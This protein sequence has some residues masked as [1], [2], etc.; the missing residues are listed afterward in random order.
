MSRAVGLVSGMVAAILVV[1]CGAGKPSK[2]ELR[3][4]LAAQV[5]RA[6]EVDSFDVEDT[7]DLGVS[8]SPLM[9]TQF[10]AK[11]HARENTYAM[12]RME[13]D[14]ALIKPVLP[15][16]EQRTLFGTATSTR[17]G[18]AWQTTLVFAS[19]A[20]APDGKARAELG[21]R[22]VLI[23]TDEERKYRLEL[24]EARRRQV[25]AR[26]AAFSR[27]IASLVESG[28]VLECEQ[29]T[30]DKKTFPCRFAVASFDANTGDVVAT[31][32]WFSLKTGALKPPNRVRGTLKDGILNLTEQIKRSE[33]GKNFTMHY[34]LQ[35][36][37]AQDALAGEF[38]APGG[39]GAMR[40]KLQ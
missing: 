40:V 13:G 21:R 27:L 7:E 11:L 16:G 19:N 33:A 38:V 32:R 30:A 1:G 10:D 6:W 8:G 14:V 34:T 20:R 31:N 9:K 22:T 26:H 25:A 18:D 23:G 4:S 36:S 2:E 35:V 5:S 3:R 17:H 39:K 24:E 37:D 15:K 29:V 12:E 28:R